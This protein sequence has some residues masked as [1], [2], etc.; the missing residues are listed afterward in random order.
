MSWPCRL[1]WRDFE[2]SDPA[3]DMTSDAATSA[4]LATFLYKIT[5][6]DPSIQLSTEVCC[7]PLPWKI[8]QIVLI[9][10]W[11]DVNASVEGSDEFVMEK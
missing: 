8:S 5:L 4:L 2:I 10:T 11:K 3:L 9:E 7:R 1:H 6:A